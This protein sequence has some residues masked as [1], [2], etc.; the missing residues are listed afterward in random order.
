[1]F[2]N[3]HG[4]NTSCQS[5]LQQKKWNIDLDQIYALN[6][7]LAI[8]YKYQ[9]VCNVHDIDI[10]MHIGMNNVQINILNFNLKRATPKSRTK[11]RVYG[12]PTIYSLAFRSRWR[13]NKKFK[14]SQFKITWG[15]SKVTVTN[16]KTIILL[17]VL[18]AHLSPYRVT[19]RS[20]TS[21]FLRSCSF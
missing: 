20:A 16:V 18:G 13:S 8:S 5:H 1:M 11:S 15:I 9:N 7:K 4:N 21:G 19:R 17:E 2:S 14:K 10:L 12:W 3:G 6:N